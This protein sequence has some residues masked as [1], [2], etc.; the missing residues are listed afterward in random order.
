MHSFGDRNK[1]K[2]GVKRLNCHSI[3]FLAILS[4][5]NFG[6]GFSRKINMK[7]QNKILLNV[8]LIHFVCLQIDFY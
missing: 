8:R 3:I 1:E 2:D 4:L 7:L 6:S 5:K